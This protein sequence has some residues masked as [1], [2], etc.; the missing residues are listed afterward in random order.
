MYVTSFCQS[1]YL[2]SVPE[3]LDW[4][5]NPKGLLHSIPKENKNHLLSNLKPRSLGKVLTQLLIVSMTDTTVPWFLQGITCGSPL[6]I[7]K[8]TDAQILFIK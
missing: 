1:W 8:S 3:N 7:P 4:L 5:T 6:L 2:T